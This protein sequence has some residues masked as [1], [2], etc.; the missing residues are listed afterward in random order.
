MEKLSEIIVGQ[1]VHVR[2]EREFH[3]KTLASVT[4]GKVV[5]LHDATKL[6]PELATIQSPNGATNIVAVS[7]LERD[8]A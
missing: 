5:K 1:N 2:N 7:L 8:P 3:A 6:H 4:R